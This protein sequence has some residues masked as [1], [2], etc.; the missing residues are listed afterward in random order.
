MISSHPGVGLEEPKIYNGF[1]VANDSLKKANSET[2]QA[3]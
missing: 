3:S 1:Y 2:Q